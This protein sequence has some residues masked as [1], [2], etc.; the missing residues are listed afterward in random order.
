MT[1]HKPP[2]QYLRRLILV[3]VMCIAFCFSGVCLSSGAEEA[4]PMPP[5]PPG[6]KFT[7]SPPAGWSNI[8]L[9]VEGRLG[10]GD[11]KAASAAARRYS[12]MF[13]LVILA[14]V[15]TDDA[16]VHRLKRM[17]IGFTTK[18]KG[19]N[20]VITVDKEEELGAELG[21]IARS[22]FKAN[23]ESLSD[24]NCVA[25]SRNHVVFDAPTIMLYDGEH[26]TMIVR[27]LVWA[28]PKSG[29]ISTFVW[30]LDNPPD[31]RNHRTMESTLQ[32]LPENMREDRVMNVK[33]DRFTFGIPSKDAFALVRIPQG[34]AIKF[35]P[36]L[37]K[38]AGH[39]NYDKAS[40]TE[41]LQ[42]LTDAVPQQAT[43]R[44]L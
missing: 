20:T 23:E 1:T 10:S 30:L 31:N 33:G 2:A 15:G 26:E 4:N 12:K 39:R 19:H 25:R 14:N 24:I 28:S 21:F 41:L 5:I 13:N 40:L 16:G 38:I 35:T 27:Y 8:V 11:M 6:T 9:F 32:Q 43:S 37:K 34:T 44:D 42:A 17:G 29:D 7:T 36:R 18:I 3:S 22:V